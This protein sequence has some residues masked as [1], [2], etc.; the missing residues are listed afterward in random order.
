MSVTKKQSYAFAKTYERTFC[1]SRRTNRIAFILSVNR[2]TEILDAFRIEW[3]Y[4]E[5][6]TNVSTW[7]CYLHSLI[8]GLEIIC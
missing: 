1:R 3:V 2:S 6:Q 7:D 4:P 8:D 5:D